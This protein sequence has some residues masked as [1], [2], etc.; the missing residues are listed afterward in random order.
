MQVRSDSCNLYTN[1]FKEK[2]QHVCTIRNILFLLCGVHF[3]VRFDLD[4]L[5]LIIFSFIL[6]IYSK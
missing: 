5:A 4:Y 1:L 2:T 6:L 3:L